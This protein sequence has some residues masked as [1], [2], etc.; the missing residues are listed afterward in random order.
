[1]STQAFGSRFQTLGNYALSNTAQVSG[2]PPVSSA[3][4]FPPITP[5]QQLPNHLSIPS[6][7]LPPPVSS[8]PLFSSILPQQQSAPSANLF[9]PVIP[10]QPAHSA[11][12]FSSMA[13]K[14][15]LNLQE[16]AEVP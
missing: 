3:Q 4:L 11:P 14:Q 7:S 2:L 13:L 8:A 12:L 1:M 6:T 16:V 10:Y 5:T 15:T 9:S